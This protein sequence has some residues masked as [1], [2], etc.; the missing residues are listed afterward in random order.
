METTPVNTSVGAN[1]GSHQN[2]P[3]M[4]RFNTPQLP[5]AY[6]S[7][8]KSAVNQDARQEI[9]NRQNKVNHLFRQRTDG[10]ADVDAKEKAYQDFEALAESFFDADNARYPTEEQ[11][12][13]I[14]DLNESISTVVLAGDQA[15]GSARAQTK[16]KITSK[17]LTLKEE[18]ETSRK[19]WNALCKEHDEESAALEKLKKGSGVGGNAIQGNQILYCP[20]RESQSMCRPSD[21]IIRDLWSMMNGPSCL[22]LNFGKLQHMLSTL[23]KSLRV[24]VRDNLPGNI[25]CILT[26]AK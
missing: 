13:T 18:A 26:T 11:N 17:I 20:F 5:A 19:N 6:L 1:H 4:K 10:R 23:K 22:E 21:D 24:E 8:S 25:H 15:A 2:N 9:I 14:N 3:I 7:N 12:R 16:A